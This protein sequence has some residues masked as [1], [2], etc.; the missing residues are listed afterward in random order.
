[1]ATFSVT[2]A[3]KNLETDRTKPAVKGCAASMD[4]P[5]LR[6]IEAEVDPMA[7]TCLDKSFPTKASEGWTALRTRKSAR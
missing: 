7:N 2:L 4:V 3:D 5:I 6:T 1:M